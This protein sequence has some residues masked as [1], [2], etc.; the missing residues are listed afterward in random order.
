[1]DFYDNVNYGFY[2]K[3]T[4]FFTWVAFL[5]LPG[6]LYLA[7]SGSGG[8]LE[9]ATAALSGTRSIPDQVAFR[10][11]C[12][13]R[14]NKQRT[15]HRFPI[16]HD[17]EPLQEKLE[18]L[19]VATTKPSLL[20]LEEVF[21]AVQA[22]FPGARQLSATLVYHPNPASLAQS[23]ADWAQTAGPDFDSLSTVVFRD[24]YRQGC[25]AMLSSRLP[26]FDLNA[27]NDK[28]GEFIQRCP[29]CGRHHAVKLARRSRTLILRCPECEKVCEVLGS[30]TD[31]VLR[32]APDF[33]TT[34][35]LA[36]NAALLRLAPAERLKRVYAAVLE[37]CHY[38]HDDKGN[39]SG[40]LEIW[41]TPA[42]TWLDASGDCEDTAILLADALISAGLDA[43]V[44]IGWNLQIG[45]HSWCVVRM[46]G[47]QHVLET[48]LEDPPATI[49]PIA[50][51]GE[52]YRAEQLFDRTH[53]YT[54]AP[55]AKSA[56]LSPYLDCWNPAWWQPI[57]DSPLV[58]KRE[59]GLD[60]P[61]AFATM[62]TP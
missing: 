27:A 26:D 18:R 29:H 30:G 47:V 32:R 36:D 20:G 51:N 39:G 44:A 13:G 46:G 52:E 10:R 17:D 2:R 38:A 59:R 11:L 50:V 31:G 33:L 24:G 21:K 28:G 48:T 54:L 60:D 40:N 43:R 53:V 1:M 7:S 57:P 6:T 61:A 12:A 8:V 15:E 58:T 37:H 3:M 19:V 5:A 55:E 49:D 42:E 34:Y 16:V 23:V 4:R 56:G 35:Q 62:P 22:D 25:L 9:S 14:I 45:Q 41:K